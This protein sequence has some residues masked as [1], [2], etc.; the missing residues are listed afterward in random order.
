MTNWGKIR[1]FCTVKSTRRT[2]FGQMLLC[3]SVV[4]FL[5]PAQAQGLF[6][7]V[8][9]VND[10]IVT[11]YEVQQRIKLLEVLNTAGDLREIALE[12]L[13]E[14]RLQFK[15]ALDAGLRPTAKEIE[16]GIEEFAS[17]GNLEPGAFLNGL[18]AEG[19]STES[20]TAFVQSGIAWRN[21]VRQRFGPLVEV[22][23]DEIDQELGLSG[24]RGTLEVLFSEIFLPTNNERNRSI[25]EQLAPQ[26]A[27]LTTTAEFE[28]A[29][30]RFSAGSSRENGGRVEK[31]LK[32]RELPAQLR[33]QVVGL[34]IGQVSPAVELPNAIGFFQLRAKREARISP[35]A[36][37]RLDYVTLV[38]AA[39]RIADIRAKADTCDDLY[40]VVKDAEKAAISRVTNTINA[41]P[42]DIALQLARLDP[43]ESHV[44]NFTNAGD[45]AAQMIMLCARLPRQS[46]DQQGDDEGATQALRDEIRNELRTRKLTAYADGLLEQL[47]GDAVIVV[48]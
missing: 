5:A 14:E 4:S 24:Q 29:A 45:N 40:G 20:F 34:K 15:A 6:S 46:A 7:P 21:L 13:I 30:R 35:Q 2:A 39:D 18:A 31:W 22:N 41:T 9:K 16:A 12:K 27:A 43:G 19:V 32:I 3:L 44:R 37:G 33:S 48:K 25:T 1:K 17:R 47:R 36:G 8:A 11:G 26:I 38:L 42:S 28:A 10:Q 23:E